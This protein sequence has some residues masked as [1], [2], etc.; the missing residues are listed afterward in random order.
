[1]EILAASLDDPDDY[2]I[3]E[4]AMPTTSN[5]L[6]SFDSTIDADGGYVLIKPWYNGED[7]SN[8]LIFD[9]TRETAT[10]IDTGLHVV[11]TQM[12]FIE[13]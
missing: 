2:T 8:I 3:Y 4:F 1:L 7:R 11:D 6:Y 9:T 10:I 5:K 12:L 13:G